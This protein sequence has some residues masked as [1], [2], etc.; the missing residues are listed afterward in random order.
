MKPASYH[1]GRVMDQLHLVAARRI[2]RDL[3]EASGGR[4]ISDE[5]VVEAVDAG[6]DAP[7]FS[8]VGYR[9]AQAALAALCD[10]GDLCCRVV[11]YT[12]RD[13]ERIFETEY[14][15]W[16]SKG[17]QEARLGAVVALV[18]AH[19]NPGRYSISV[20]ERP[21]SFQSEERDHSRAVCDAIALIEN[22]LDEREIAA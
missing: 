11:G 3:V 21:G 5:R 6:I 17:R 4:F 2:A 14:A 9:A 8:Q 15:T 10:E 20:P 16:E 22:V 12:N 13:G 19:P 1:L 7:L 18:L